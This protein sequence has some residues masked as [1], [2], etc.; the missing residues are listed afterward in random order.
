MIFIAQ[1]F[2]QYTPVAKHIQSVCNLDERLKTGDVTL[3]SDIQKVIISGVEKNFYSFA[4]KYCS[5]HNPKD[6]PIYDS[7]V[8]KVLCYFEENDHFAGFK[9][10]DLRDYEKFKGII[11]SFREFYGLEKYDLKQIDQYLW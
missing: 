7:Y 11:I 6:Y 10:K 9:T 5:H 2:L 4:S 1:I 3:V 8:G